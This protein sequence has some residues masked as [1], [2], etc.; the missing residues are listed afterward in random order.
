MVECILLR[1]ENGPR[2]ILPNARQYFSKELTKFK[3]DVISGTFKFQS[4]KDSYVKVKQSCWAGI[5]NITQVTQKLIKGRG[6]QEPRVVWGFDGGVKKLTAGLAIH[7]LSRLVEKSL[8]FSSSGRRM[9]M[10]AFLGDRFKVCAPTRG[11]IIFA[12]A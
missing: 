11:C 3:D 7:E 6:V 1:D 9:E 8:S 2:S 4:S 12:S 10:V 5:K